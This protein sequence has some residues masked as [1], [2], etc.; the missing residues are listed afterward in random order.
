MTKRLKPASRLNK[1]EALEELGA[2]AEVVDFEEEFSEESK[3]VDLRRLV[4]EG[5]EAAV[6]S[7]DEDES[8]EESDE[9][10]DEE[11]DDV[12]D[13]EEET[14]VVVSES[15]A[16]KGTGV[17]VYDKNGKYIRTYSPKVHGKD[18]A[19]LAKQFV[20]KKGREGYKTR[21]VK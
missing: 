17:H 4:A 10:D 20:S 7:D 15:A 19:K 5:R 2:L 18:Y 11:V 14:P 8:D 3:L 1:E 12:D 13:D 6:E 9:A 16:P 21:E